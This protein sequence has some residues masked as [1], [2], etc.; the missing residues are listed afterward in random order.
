MDAGS[1]LT[2]LQ[3]VM[4]QTAEETAKGSAGMDL[5]SAAAFL[6]AGLSML[7]AAGAGLSMGYA[8]GKAAEGVA[9][10]P[11]ALGAVTRVM[12]I[13]QAVAES[14]AIYALVIALLLLF[15]KI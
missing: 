2:A 9:R 11:Q 14:T 3:T 1:L 15:V 12:L 8:A 7:G 13:G 6:G 5:K 10:N 4:G